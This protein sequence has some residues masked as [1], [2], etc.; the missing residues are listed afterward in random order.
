VRFDRRGERGQTLVEFSLAI[1]I[2]LFILLA[3]VDLARAVYTLNG[4]NGA[5]REIAR[6][7]SVHPGP[8]PLGT[9]VET[10]AEVDTQRVF[11][12]DLVV[13]SY[14]C[15]DIANVPVTGNCQSG[16][17]VRVNVSVTLQPLLAM[18]GPFDFASSSSAEIQCDPEK[19][20]NAC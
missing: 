10:V 9:S 12:P 3:M 18:F 13:D 1:G 15:V 4:L 7:T 17:W 6:T 16:D 11:V 5:A 8:G 19:T 14:D 2:F 20:T